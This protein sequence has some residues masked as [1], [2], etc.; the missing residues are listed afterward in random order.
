MS[1]QVLNI[2]WKNSEFWQKVTQIRVSQV[3]VSQIRASQIRATQ[4]RVSQISTTEISSNHRELHGAIFLCVLVFFAHVWK[5]VTSWPK[6]QCHTQLSPSFVNFRNVRK[7]QDP[8]TQRTLFCLMWLRYRETPEP[9]TWTSVLCWEPVFPLT[10]SDISWKS[11]NLD[12][13]HN[14]PDQLHA[15]SWTR[16]VSD[17]ENKQYTKSWSNRFR[18]DTWRSRALRTM[19]SCN[20]QSSPLSEV[21]IF[22]VT[23]QQQTSCSQRSWNELKIQ[24]AT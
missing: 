24:Q 1:S 19:Q 8:C 9:G 11:L 7:K 17:A 2:E 6:E 16:T 13:N 23:K 4:I 22:V 10:L 12:T 18:T 21:K 3:R 5:F 14:Y 15:R 20:F